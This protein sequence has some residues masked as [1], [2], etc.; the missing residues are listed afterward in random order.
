LERAQTQHRARFL[1]GIERIG[2]FGGKSD[3]LAMNQ[4][5]GGNPG[6]YKETLRR[7]AEAKPEDLRQA[8]AKWLTDGV[9]VLEVHPFPTYTKR[10]EGADRS[11][12]PAVSK[13]PELDLP[14]LQ[15][16]T[17]RNGLKVIMAER[18]ETPVVEFELVLDAGYAADQFAS[19]GVASMALAMLDE[20]TRSRSSL[21]ISEAL[22]RLGANLGTSSSV[23]S[24]M[25]SLSALKENLDASLEIYADVILNP[26]FPDADFQRLKRQSLA[27]IRQEKSSPG[28]T[29]MRLLPGL[30]Y[31]KNHAYGNPLTGS[32]TEE[33]VG[34]MTRQDLERFHRAWFQPN[35]ATLVVVGDAN[36]AEITPRLEAHFSAWKSGEAAPKKNIAAVGVPEKRVVYLV[37]KPGAAQSLIIA[38]LPTAPAGSADDI[39]IAAMNSILGGTFTSRI[40]MNLRE[41]K[42]WSYGA[43]S[44]LP[45][46][47]G[48]RLFYGFAPVQTDK[49]KESM[50]ELAKEFE[51]IL[52]DRPASAEELEKSQMQ[53]TLSLPGR[54][55]T[56]SALRNAIRESVVFGRP[57]DYYETLAAKVNALA[58]SDIQAAAERVVRPGNMVWIVVGDLAKIE[59]GIRELGFDEVKRMDPDGNI[60]D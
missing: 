19:P 11:K 41:D 2:G 44:V 33:S 58:L 46:S 17:L 7:V 28:A 3:I 51:Q 31:G 9:Y 59:A 22:D 38:G 35:A 30:I 14:P 1:R 18:R 23:D 24:S 43:R 40:N 15:K 27:G 5:Y 8:A 10:D 52:G 21:E 45:D 50:M 13:F 6:F 37:D 60:S 47:R 56:K 42:H 32:G 57:D 36:L 34:A 39:A 53:R 12:A 55:E 29:A 4:V 26:S 49:T 48:P 20:G 16:T 25:V 54:F